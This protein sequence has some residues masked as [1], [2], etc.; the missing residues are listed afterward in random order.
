MDP[1]TIVPEKGRGEGGGAAGVERWRFKPRP[2]HVSDLESTI[3]LA[4][5]GVKASAL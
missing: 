3:P 4:A 1:R 5:P 2:G